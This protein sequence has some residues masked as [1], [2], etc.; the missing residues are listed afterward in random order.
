MN[1]NLILRSTGLHCYDIMLK[2]KNQQCSMHFRS[3]VNIK[4]T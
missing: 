4:I 1:I 2:K 3:T